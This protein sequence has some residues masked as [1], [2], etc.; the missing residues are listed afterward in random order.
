M[1][2]ANCLG[3]RLPPYSKDSGKAGSY[4]GSLSQRESVITRFALL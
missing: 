4:L 1:P 3:V 2:S